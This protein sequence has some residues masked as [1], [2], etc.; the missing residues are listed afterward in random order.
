MTRNRRKFSPLIARQMRPLSVALAVLLLAGAA[1]SWFA[2][3]HTYQLQI[4]AEIAA[5]QALLLQRYHRL[6]IV[7]VVEAIDY[8]L[9]YLPDAAPNGVYLLIDREG[10]RI[11]GNLQ[12]MPAA[13][14]P[15]EWL[16]FNGDVGGGSERIIA[17]ISPVDDYFTLLVGRR[18]APA[19]AFQRGAAFALALAGIA[20]FMA[21]LLIFVRQSKMVANR[22][23]LITDAIAGARS[24][25]R[26]TQ[27]PETGDDEISALGAEINSL[28]GTLDRQLDHLRNMSKVIAHEIRT[29]LSSVR[30][31]LSAAITSDENSS[32]HVAAALEQTRGV[33]ELTNSLLEITDNEAAHTRFLERLDLA[34]ITRDIARLFEDVAAEKHVSVT[35][36]LEPAPVLGGK[37]LLVRLVSNLVENAINASTTGQTIV[38][39]TGAGHSA[40]WIEVCDEGAGIPA[41]TLDAYLAA[42][43]PG[44][45]NNENGG[46]GV[47]LKLVRA[48]ALRHGA[49]VR[50]S[51]DD[52]GFCIRADFARAAQY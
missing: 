11:T 30:K 51:N 25:D 12:H 49:R 39:R 16:T 26:K 41:A 2:I 47:G 17:R 31:E 28:L 5:D 38:C 29:P 10:N 6:K 34:D 1:G 15:M 18:L 22:F 8:R 13:A 14:K 42:H 27:A 50:F 20:M 48:I 37:W 23:Q 24:G 44:R 21:I 32:D 33:L 43:S 3:Q 7:A 40:A 4:R 36:E 19:I 45:D 46:H 9:D 35:L 52:K